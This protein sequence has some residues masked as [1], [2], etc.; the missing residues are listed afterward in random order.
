MAEPQPIDDIAY[1]IAATRCGICRFD[2]H[3][4]EP[5]VA[6]KRGLFT[7][8][9]LIMLVLCLAEPKLKFR[10]VGQRSDRGIPL[11]LKGLRQRTIQLV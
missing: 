9:S 5:V 8:G 7:A 6:G 4:D 3:D 10:L 1:D 11:S 2:L